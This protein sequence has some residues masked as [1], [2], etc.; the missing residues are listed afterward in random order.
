M[1]EQIYL[2]SLSD[3]HEGKGEWSISSFSILVSLMI[4]AA[5]ILWVAYSSLPHEYYPVIGLSVLLLVA[6]LS[7][8]ILFRRVR[9]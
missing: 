6:L 9:I 1:L 2:E 8:I 5:A 7:Y 4:V 3:Q